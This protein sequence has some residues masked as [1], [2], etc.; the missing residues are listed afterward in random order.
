MHRWLVNSFL[1]QC[2]INCLKAETINERNEFTFLRTRPLKRRGGQA[3][4]TLCKFMFRFQFL[5]VVIDMEYISCEYN[6]A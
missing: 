1:S 5:V 6:F 3:L 4:D 2:S